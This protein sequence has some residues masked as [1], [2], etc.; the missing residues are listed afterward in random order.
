[1]AAGV[2]T[3]P[4]LHRWGKAALVVAGLVILLVILLV[5]LFAD[6]HADL[7]TEADIRHGFNCAEFYNDC[8]GLYR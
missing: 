4:K 6:L 7:T 3:R 1:M 8:R 5:G 2:K